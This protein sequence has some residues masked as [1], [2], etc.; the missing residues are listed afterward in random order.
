MGGL[1]AGSMLAPIT[2]IL[3]VFEITSNYSIIL[4]V[5]VAAILSTVVTM[6]LSGGLSVYTF[7]LARDG[8]RLFR[9]GSPD[10]LRTRRVEAHLRPRVETASPGEPRGRDEPGA[11]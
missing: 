3:M 11:C 8:I 7:K 9:G 5:M 10:L 6:R 4:P 1:V 2:A